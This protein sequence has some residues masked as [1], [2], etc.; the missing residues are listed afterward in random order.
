MQGERRGRKLEPNGDE[1]LRVRKDPE[2]MLGISLVVDEADDK[3][4]IVGIEN[5]SLDSKKSC[6]LSTSPSTRGCGP[7]MEEVTEAVS[8]RTAI[9]EIQREL[10]T[11]PRVQVRITRTKYC[12]APDLIDRTRVG[13]SRSTITTRTRTRSDQRSVQRR[14]PV[15]SA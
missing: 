13:R 10:R 4:E 1:S 9:E 11:A 3:I 15:Q 7:E 14:C 5:G 2:A 6:R 12:E 8:R